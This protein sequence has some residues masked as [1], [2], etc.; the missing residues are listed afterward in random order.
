M[1]K[2]IFLLLFLFPVFLFS[3]TAEEKLLYTLTTYPGNADS[4]SL[5]Y[6]KNTGV[7][8]YVYYIEKDNKSF[9]ISSA[10]GGSISEKYDAVSSMD[11]KFDSQGNYYT[12]TTNYRDDYGIDNNFL[13]SNGKVIKAFDMI[14]G[15]SSFVN[16]VD[17][18]VSIFQEFDQYKIGYYSPVTGFRQSEGYELIKP[19]YRSLTTAEENTYGEEMFFKN[20]DGKRGFIGLKNG[21]AYLIFGDNVTPTEYS[22]IMEYSFTTD[23]FGNIV[24]IAKTGGR[25]YTANGNE[26]VVA[27]S[28]EFPKFDI[29]NAPVMF[30][31]DNQPVYVTMDSV[32][33]DLYISHLVAGNAVQDVYLNSAKTERAP[34][35]TGGIY[36][37]KIDENGNITYMAGHMLDLM[38]E[39]NYNYNVK[40]YFVRNGIAEDLGINVGLVRYWKNGEMIYGAKES[41]YDE[42]FQ[43]FLLNGNDRRKINTVS[44]DAYSDYGFTPDGGIYYIAE[45]FNYDD[46]KNYKSSNYFVYLDG[47]LIAQPPGI[48][49][50]GFNYSEFT[51]ASAIQFDTRGNYTYVTEELL[52]TVNYVYA[53]HVW[54]NGTKLPFRSNISS[55]AKAYNYISNLSYLDNSRLFFIGNITYPGDAYITESEILIDNVP[56]GKTY[57]SIMDLY[58]DQVLKIITFRGSRGKEIYDVTLRLN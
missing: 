52:D 14:E 48:S 50:Q 24:Y 30:T 13:I 8:A 40:N 28:Q 3:Q 54:T 10:K 36:E 18:F 37:V 53:S 4:Y 33:Q 27:G 56:A 11:I 38:T 7:Y 43:V 39:E 31:P 16:D 45:N 5:A 20:A 49:F 2:M 41:K 57:N 6:D 1:N 42:L 55:T 34:D 21:R 23:N 26:F 19:V 58:Y 17:E 44:Y 32:N 47:R 51:P 9:I 15:Y 25:F 46:E 35:L 12:I 29:V 22:D